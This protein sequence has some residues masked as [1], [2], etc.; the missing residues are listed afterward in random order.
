[1]CFFLIKLSLYI[2]Y[3]FNLVCFFVQAVH[4]LYFEPQ[5]KRVSLNI[6]PLG[7]APANKTIQ[8]YG[9]QLCKSDKLVFTA[10]PPC[11]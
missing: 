4:A 1:M 7:C 5:E 8:Y 6:N 11:L 2:V 3:L 10:C 9:G